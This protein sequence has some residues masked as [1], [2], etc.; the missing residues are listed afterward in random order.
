MAI[1]KNLFAAAIISAGAVSGFAAEVVSATD[2]PAGGEENE[3]VQK[4]NFVAD[5]AQSYFYSKIYQLK[6]V[7]AI[8]IATFVKTAVMRCNGE[9]TVSTLADKD[10]DMLIVTAKDVMFDY[11]DKMVEILDRPGKI[12]HSGSMIDGTGVAYGTYRP[13]FRGTEEMRDIII[14]GGISSGEENSTVKFD[15]KTGIFYFK[16]SPS[17]VADIKEKLSWLDREIPQARLELKIYEVRDSDLKDIGIDYLAW[18]NGPGLDLFSAGYEAL[19]LRVAETIINELATSGFD[20]FG[21]ATY[22]FGGFYTAP[23]F[24]LSFVRLLQQN[25]KAIINSTASL[26]VTNSGEE[27]NVAFSPEYQ[28]ISKEPEYHQTSV[29]V[30]GEATLDATIS[31]AIITDRVVNF[32]Y[33]LDG[34]NVV[35]RNNMDAEISAHTITNSAVTLE[36]GKEKIIADWTRNTQVEQTI[37]IPFLCELPILKYIFGTTTSNEEIVHYIVTAQAVDVKYNDSIDAGVISEFATVAKK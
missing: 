32:N 36:F 12:D 10:G 3:K 35:E 37:G 33:L 15:E 2:L 14:E 29:T 19:N 9:A 30:G 11:I 28:H 1:F 20:L 6:H 17:R 21:T 8:D 25:G 31:N 5:D 7:K 24:D 23:A 27:F 18:K 16:D 4:I 13:K 34:C 26:L 22:G